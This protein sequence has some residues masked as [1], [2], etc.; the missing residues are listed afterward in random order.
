[1]TVTAMV[2]HAEPRARDLRLTVLTESKR[3]DSPVVVTRRD[4]QPAPGQ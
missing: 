1:M 2:W 3:R 4:V